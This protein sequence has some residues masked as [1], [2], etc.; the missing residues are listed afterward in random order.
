MLL[1]AGAQLG[2]YRIED[3]VGRG[4][5]GV[6][7]RATE[8]AL[9]RP[10]ALKLIAPELADDA[11]FRERFLR[12]SR[13]AAS[14]DHPGILPVY[15]AGEVD[16]QL[17]IA[18]RFVDGI[19]LRQLVATAG[20][21]PPERALKL[22]GQVADALDAAHARRLVHRDVKPG[23]VLVDAADH[24]YLCDFGLTKQIGAAGATL[25]GGLA[26]SLDYLAPEQIRHG[27]VDGRADQYALACVL[28][29]VLSG[30]PPFR[31]D[32]EAQTL[33]AHMQEDAAPVREQPEL[34]EVLAR[35]LAKEPSD[36]YESCNAFVDD[37]RAAAGLAPSFSVV[38]R[39]R[40]RTGRWLVGA[41]AAVL[42][43]AAVAVALA[44][45][46][47]EGVTVPPNSVAVVDPQSLDTVAA[48]GVGNTPTA[49]AA[50]SRWTWAVNSNDGIGTISRIDARTRRVV[51][52]F[53]VGGTPRVLVAAFGSLWVGTTEG[54]VARVEPDT[55]LIERSWTLPN[56]GETNN[57]FVPDHGAGWLAAGRDTVWAASTRAIS[58]ID[59]ASSQLTSRQSATWGPLAYGFGSLWVLGDE[60]ERLSP[61]TLRRV[62]AVE[63]ADG[64]FALAAGS[65]GVWVAN[66]D[67]GTAVQIDPVQG[68]VSRTY[69][70]G[71]APTSV[72]VGGGVAWVTTDAG[73]IARIDP[74]TGELTSRALGGAPRHVSYAATGVWV[75]VD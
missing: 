42:A 59:P 64:S 27:D 29:E 72:A 11:G 6:V 44:V 60:L 40:R 13:L 73:K 8:V 54:R 19:D 43:V 33:W 36:R 12:E 23:N 49:T 66:E 53:S 21:Q 17:Y 71:G 5:M 62:D 50:S 63:L 28:Y 68:V 10:V 35:G 3:V 16:G 14:L 55:D 52:T 34:E 20:P 65:G 61:R 70:V 45:R 37:A 41:G 15:A 2:G 1:D 48:V 74:R 56:A 30:A 51:S 22:V 25:A 47:G 57:A 39:R 24:C 4:G 46:G 58:A 67:D 32:T 7:Y 75:S 38:R 18:S 31:R 26:G 69:D 9:E